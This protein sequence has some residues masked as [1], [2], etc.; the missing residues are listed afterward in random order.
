MRPF[1]EMPRS[2][3][4]Q[5]RYVL[6]DIDDTITMHG[7]LP[8][9]SYEA[10]QN[11]RASGR[12]VVLI[13]GRPAG[14]CDMI[15]R[16]FPVD[17]VIG[18]NGALCFYRD[19]DQVRQL[20]HDDAVTRAKNLKR[21]RAMAEVIIRDFDGTVLAQDNPWR[22]SDVAVDF[23]ESVPPLPLPVARAIKARFEAQGATAK[24]SSIHVN[25]WF[26]A[27]DKYAMF[28]RWLR[29]VRGESLAAIEASA[30]YVGDSPNDVP[31]F[32]RFAHSV[33]V[34]AITRYDL[35][36]GD[37]PAW[38]TKEDAAQGFAQVAHALLSHPLR[39]VKSR[40]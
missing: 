4:E 27:Y 8:A 29:D 16:F 18:E 20:W 6:S 17:A 13:T 5:V 33:G 31:M 26:G 10:L 9:Q 30:I 15:A 7:V 37:L 40:G 32:R 3:L 19:G 11:L 36:G 14:W 12:A 21:L 24:V 28:S 34:H 25:A 1:T 38:V 39:R 2:A 35:P 23:A 22:A